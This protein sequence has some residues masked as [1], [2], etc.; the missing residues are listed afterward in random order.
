MW[1]ENS[2][3]SSFAHRLIEHMD[4]V[5]AQLTATSLLESHFGLGGLI[6]YQVAEYIWNI[7]FI[8]AYIYI[9]IY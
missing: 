6:K 2:V 3:P 8:Y 9:H 4:T 5:I 1:L 7:P